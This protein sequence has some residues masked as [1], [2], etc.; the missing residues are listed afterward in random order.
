MLFHYFICNNIR[1][2]NFSSLGLRSNLSSNYFAIFS[3]LYFLTSRWIIFTVVHR[4]WRIGPTAVLVILGRDTGPRRKLFF[5]FFITWLLWLPK[6]DQLTLNFLFIH[7]NWSLRLI[8]II[9]HM[10][11]RKF[12]W[13]LHKFQLSFNQLS[14]IR[15]QRL[16]L[17]GS[18]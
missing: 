1:I 2:W 13:M 7:T 3:L 17:D 9:K 15:H 18:E 8:S 5:I 6:R 11:K 12:N 10:T 14:L 4:I 16:F